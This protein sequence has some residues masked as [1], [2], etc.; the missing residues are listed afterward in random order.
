TITVASTATLA[1]KAGEQGTLVKAGAGELIF[2][3]N[4]TYTGD[5][6][7]LGGTLTL[8]S[9]QGLSDTGAVTLSNTSGV[10]LKVNASETIGSL[11]G[12][13]TT[14]GNITLA[15]GQNL[16]IVQTGA[17]GLVKSGTG[18]LALTK[19]NNSFVGGVT[20]EGG[21]LTSDYGSISS[22]NTIVVNSGGTLGMLRTDTWGGATATSTIPV[23]INDGG[24]MTSDNQFN[25]LRDLTL[26]GG[27]VSLNG[28]LASTL[29]AFAFGG[30]VTAG[31]A[32]TSTIAVVSGTNNNIRLG[33]Q[34]TNEPTTFDVS[35]PNGQLLVGAALWDNFGSIS[36]LTKSGNGKMVLSA[37]NAYTGPTAVTGGTLQI[38]NGGTMGSILVNS[39]LSVSNGATLAFNR[40][41]NYGGALNHTIS[42]AG[43]VAIN[44]GNLT[45]NAGGSSGYSTNLG[46]VINN[47]ATATMGH[48]DMFGGTGW[49]AT[50]S[51]GFTVNAG[52]TLASSNNF[53][54][55]WN[56]NLNGGT[57]LA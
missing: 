20:I 18:K 9:G 30:T 37:A 28:G 42:G 1:D 10:T 12:G 41:D 8:N 32:V 48:S 17:G 5:T 14:G 26:N 56:L 24:N 23:I 43:T 40:T 11:R 6:T 2:S 4:N 39:A 55:L 36:G 45:L 53:N 13:G 7:V 54:T 50:T 34:A 3:G 21:I 33:R 49:D 27:T 35:D 15:E 19:N 46:F 57:L 38:G 22:A 16:T 25:T 52:G 51:P 44:G 29:S 47:G 31:G